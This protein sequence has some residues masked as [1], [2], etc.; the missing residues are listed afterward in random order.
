M[1][2]MFKI[3]ESFAQSFNPGRATLG[4]GHAE[5]WNGPHWIK[6][7][8]LILI[9]AFFIWWI[10]HLYFRRGKNSRPR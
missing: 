10:Y 8:G 7:L 4:K 9:I 6:V 3:N 2:V 1:V 5:T